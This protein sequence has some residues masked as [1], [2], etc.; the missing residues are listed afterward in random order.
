LIQ[1]VTQGLKL[2]WILWNLGNRKSEG[3]R[4]LGKPNE[5]SC[6]MKGRE[7]LD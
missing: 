2:G 4:P 3:K 5:P 1:N 6:S 7:F